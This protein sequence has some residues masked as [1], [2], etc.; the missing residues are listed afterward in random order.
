MVKT[1][2]ELPLADI[3]IGKRHRTDL[4]DIAELADSI[5]RLG[6]LQ[7]IGVTA[8]A[9][10][11]FGHRRIEA[12]RLLG[13]E[14]IPARIIDIE[15]SIAGERDEN[16]CRKDFTPSERVAIGRAVEAKYG[17]RQGRRTDKQLVKLE[18]QV[19][20]KPG[21]KTRDYAAETS[22]FGSGVSYQQA[23]TV[24]D[25]GVPELIEAMD[26]GDISIKDAARVATDYKDS[27]DRQLA[28]VNGWENATLSQIKKTAFRTT[29]TGDD[30]WYTPKEYIDEARAAMGGVDLDPASNDFAQG[31]FVRAASYFTQAD[32]GLS[33]E[34]HGS[35]WLNPPY[36]KTKVGVFT[37]KLLA[38]IEA[39]RVTQ[40]VMLVNNC[41]D[42]AWFQKALGG[43]QRVC[44]VKGRINFWSPQEYQ[45]ESPMYGSA[46]FY[47]GHRAAEFTRVF[48][49]HGCVLPGGGAVAK[50]IFDENDADKVIKLVMKRARELAA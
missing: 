16:E 37:D 15:H 46:F 28:V 12:Y 10:L 29:T 26:R 36:S 43:A 42:T 14:T 13:R 47:F 49:K 25:N 21:Q 4:G 27:P 34:W 19:G 35:V 8:N 1:L 30:E 22:G 39:G 40:A 2:F 17:N 11:I 6:L 24:V 3:R 18:T 32:D 7:P 20:P 48:T 33:R 45:N 50:L 44:F 31:Q 41:T 9:E 38:E 5:E 23:Q